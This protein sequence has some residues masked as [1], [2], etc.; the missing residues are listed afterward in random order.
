MFTKMI[1]DIYRHQAQHQSD[2]KNREPSVKKAK[3]YYEEA[4]YISD[5]E[6][7]WVLEN[8]KD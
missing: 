1:A 2:S 3:N 6:S 4:K 7:E 5:Y 8:Y